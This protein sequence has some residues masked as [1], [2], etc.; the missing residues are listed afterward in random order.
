MTLGVTINELVRD[1]AEINRINE[2]DEMCS[3]C[4]CMSDELSFVDGRLLCP[5]C[6]TDESI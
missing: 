6:K 4:G 2:G 3:R 1:L 5:N